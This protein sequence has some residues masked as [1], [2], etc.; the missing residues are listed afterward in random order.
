MSREGCM[1]NPLFCI[2]MG[3]LGAPIF[4]ALKAHAQLKGKYPTGSWVSA[5]FIVLLGYTIYVS[6]FYGFIKL[7][8]KKDKVE[9]FKNLSLKDEDQTNYEKVWRY[10]NKN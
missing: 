9:Y 3:I 2:V 8:P 5:L 6:A 7:F 4:A 10:R 1:V